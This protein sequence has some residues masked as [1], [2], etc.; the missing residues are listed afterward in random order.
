MT[1]PETK[2]SMGPPP[3]PTQ[4]VQTPD[5]P[6]PPTHSPRNARAVFTAIGFLGLA[7]G[8][9]YLWHLIQGLT[10]ADPIDPARIAALEAQLRGFHQRII[11]LEQRPPAA[12]PPAP[13]N[14]APLEARLLALEQRPPPQTPTPAPATAAPTDLAPLEARIAATERATRRAIQLQAA[15]SALHDGAPLGPLPDAPPALA[16]F[17][18]IAP[19][20]LATLRRDFTPAATAALAASLPVEETAIS[21]Q[22]WRR[23]AALVTVRQGDAVLFGPP[24]ALVLTLAQTRLDAGDLQGALAALDSLDPGAAPAMA[25]WRR[26]AQALLDARAALAALARG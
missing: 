16:R 20:T 17:A 25:P 4:P 2:P 9:F 15:T 7:A 10:P 18:T 26:D 8:L 12:Q 14:L 6:A 13:A 24:A 11:A 5:K 21:S 1:D 19:P 23:L 3:P 22:I